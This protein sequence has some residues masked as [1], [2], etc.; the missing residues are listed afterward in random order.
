MPEGDKIA[1][2]P[3]GHVRLACCVTQTFAAELLLCNY[4]TN[5]TD[6]SMDT[7]E[8]FLF[9]K[10][11]RNAKAFDIKSDLS[12]ND[13]VFSHRVRTEKLLFVARTGR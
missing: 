2:R 12:V 11:R 1:E 13:D 7:S 9:G 4:R 3:R 8:R 5:R 6:V 10:N